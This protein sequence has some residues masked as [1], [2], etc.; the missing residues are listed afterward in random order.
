[1]RKTKKYIYTLIT[2]FILLLSFSL[3]ILSIEYNADDVVH[4]V[5]YKY[6]NVDGSY[7]WINVAYTVADNVISAAYSN[8]ATRQRLDIG[9]NSTTVETI[10]L[11]FT[12]FNVDTIMNNNSEY[13]YMY[14]TGSSNTVKR[15]NVN[16]IDNHT[17]SVSYS[18]IL[19]TP[20]QADGLRLYM[21]MEIVSTVLQ[22]KDFSLKIND[23]Q[24]IIEKKIDQ[25]NENIEAVES[26]VEDIYDVIADTETVDLSNKAE[27]EI[28]EKIDNKQ[29]QSAVDVWKNFDVIDYAVG[30]NALMLM[31]TAYTKTAFFKV[32]MSVLVSFFALFVIIRGL[33]R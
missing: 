29:A 1:M 17:F 23:R 8:D 32:I 5:F 12:V 27:A 31:S 11:S 26:K 24:Y 16:K 3:D 6:V 21:G 19:S 28:I 7:D 2:L 25:I 30:L 18:E 33:K 22:I 4:L 13:N 9:F 10:E 15:Y 14:F 20:F